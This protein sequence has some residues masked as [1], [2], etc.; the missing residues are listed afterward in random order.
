MS[1]Q[2]LWYIKK[3]RSDCP[4]CLSNS[5]VRIEIYR[6]IR[7]KI[8]TGDEFVITLLVRQTT[9]ANCEKCDYKEE[10][11]EEWKEYEYP[12]KNEQNFLKRRAFYFKKNFTYKAEDAFEDYLKSNSNDFH[13][14]WEYGKYLLEKG[15]LTKSYFNLKHSI[16]INKYFI[17]AIETIVDVLYRILN[18]QNEYWFECMQYFGEFATIFSSYESFINELN[19][20]L[21]SLMAHY[22][23]DQEI[24]PSLYLKSATVLEEKKLYPLAIEYYQYVINASPYTVEKADAAIRLALLYTKLQEYSKAIQSLDNSNLLLPN[25]LIHLYKSN[26]YRKMNHSEMSGKE[27]SKFLIAIDDLLKIKPEEEKLY[28]FKGLGLE[29]LESSKEMI[30]YYKSVI[31]DVKMD[32]NFRLIFQRRLDQFLSVN[33]VEKIFS[34]V[35][36]CPIC[37]SSEITLH[38]SKDFVAGSLVS[39]SGLNTRF[40]SFRILKKECSHCGFE[41][42][43]YENWEEIESEY[44]S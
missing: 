41:W 16:K 33:T 36:L 12:I 32:L 26:V 13:M 4:V 40:F 23:S 10:S 29:F 25:L 15:D 8:F 38:T 14:Y 35:P 28:Y 34:K 3:E 27:L 18:A 22:N 17:P 6:P 43:E 21:R 39:Q 2:K 31:R 24:L 1:E 5:S 9:Q 11:S 44:K 7:E 30:Q 19:S 20:F 42:K 37:N